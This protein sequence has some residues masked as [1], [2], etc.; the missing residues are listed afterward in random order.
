FLQNAVAGRMQQN[1]SMLV[2]FL[3]AIVL[4]I[5]VAGVWWGGLLGYYAVY[6]AVGT[7]LIVIATRLATQRTVTPVLH[8]GWRQRFPMVLP[9]PVWRF[10]SAL[11]VLTFVAPFAPLFVHYRL[12]SIHGAETA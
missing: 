4:A 10:S 2:G 1:R 6:A 3:H 7:A 8:G 9:R 12:L 5:A 11:M